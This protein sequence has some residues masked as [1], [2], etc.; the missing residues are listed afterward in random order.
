MHDRILNAMAVWIGLMRSTTT[1]K[2][3]LLDTAV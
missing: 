3:A 2:F 1:T